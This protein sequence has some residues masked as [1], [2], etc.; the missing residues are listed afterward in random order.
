[1]G[2]EIYHIP[3]R[4]E[5]VLLL[6]L[7]QKRKR[8]RKPGDILEEMREL[9]YS[10]SGNV[11]DSMVAMVDKPAPN[12]YIRGGKLNEIKDRIKKHKVN[13]VIAS[14]D[15]SPTQS[16]NLSEYLKIKVVDRTALILD[17]FAQHAKS[18]DGKL[19][20]ELAQY[21]YLLP[22]LSS[23]W[24]KFSRL[25]GGIGTRGPG[26]QILE[27]D[28]RKIR[29]HITKLNRDIEK[30]KKHRTVVRSSRK[31]KDFKIVSIV[32]YT[33]AGKSTLL[34][35]LTGADIIVEDKLFAT[36]DPVTRKYRMPNGKDVLFTDTVGFLL[37]LPHNL[38]KA[39]HG[40]LEEVNEAD[41]I[42]V[43]IDT[44][45]PENGLHYKVVQNILK[46]VNA[47]STPQIIAL[48]KIDLISEDEKQHVMYDYEDAYAISAQTGIGIEPLMNRLTEKLFADED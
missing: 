33:N 11:V 25:G 44:S 17:I 6:I 24:E 4:G 12:Y 26:E 41:V 23:I 28:K 21:T 42:L 15:L 5:K 43:V 18:R 8:M 32:G 1:M 47:E 22:R 20:V 3:K 40:T 14:I 9:V 39:F 19:Q 29:K 46:E 34:R 30:L 27:R 10:S 35:Q 36:L 37:D 16:R 2:E 38:V 48:N 31:R 7:M 13:S 45:N